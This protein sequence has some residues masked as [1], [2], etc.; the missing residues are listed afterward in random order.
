MI[1]Q[2][3]VVF[4]TLFFSVIA[5]SVHAGD[6]TNTMMHHDMMQASNDA[7]LS[8][9]L[10]PMMKQHQLANMRS[11]VAAVQTIVGL[12]AEE[13]FDQAAKVAHSQLGLTE[14]M[15]NMCNMFDNA[16]FRKLGLAF[17]NS[18]DALAVVLKTKN[19]KKSLQA[20]HTTMRYCVQCHATF[21]Q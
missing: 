5:M 19:T 18:A 9:G 6:K 8:L 12:I 21:R 2:I 16:R 4:F 13:K 1:R 20:L 14:A 11:H 3:T 7:R 10:S 17:H 15:K